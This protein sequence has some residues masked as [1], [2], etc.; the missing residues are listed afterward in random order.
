MQKVTCTTC[1][2]ENKVNHKYCFNCGYELPKVVVEEVQDNTIELIHKRKKRRNLI[3]GFVVA[4]TVIGLM[5]ATVLSMQKIIKPLFTGKILETAVSEVNKGCPMMIDQYTRL[6]SASVIS[7]N[8]LQY[9][10]TLINTELSE[11]NQDTVKKYL[12]P[13]IINNVKTSPEMK[14]YRDLKTTFIYSYRDKNG[15][16]ILKFPVTPD[17]YQ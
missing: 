12:F 6:D 13:E 14:V 1:G 2:S 11:I 15:L 17:M 16:A 10:Y 3:I 8:S 5:S 7:D 4:F 9:N